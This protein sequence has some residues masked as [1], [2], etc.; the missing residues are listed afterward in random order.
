M[1]L[2]MVYS[3]ITIFIIQFTFVDLWYSLEIIDYLNTAIIQLT[4]YL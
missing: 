4:Y 2:E 1:S 3:F